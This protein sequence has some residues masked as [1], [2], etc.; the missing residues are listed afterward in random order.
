MPRWWTNSSACPP[1]HPERARP[2][3]YPMNRLYLLAL[4]GLAA[5]PWIVYSP[6]ILLPNTGHQGPVGIFLL[7]ISAPLVADIV[8]L[9]FR[10]RDKST[11]QTGR[12]LGIAIATLWVCHPI[13]LES[14]LVDRIM[15]DMTVATLLAINL[16]LRARESTSWP[17]LLTCG[18]AMFCE[19]FYFSHGRPL[20]PVIVLLIHWMLPGKT[21][22]WP[23]RYWIAIWAPVLVALLLLPW[24]QFYER[25]VI[26][27]PYASF[28][29]SWTELIATQPFAWAE[30]LSQLVWPHPTAFKA[31]MAPTEL[32]P[33]WAVILI[34]AFL[35]LG[36]AHLVYWHQ[37]L[38]G[39]LILC[40]VLAMA[41]TTT[42]PLDIGQF[43]RWEV[44]STSFLTLAWV[45]I[46]SGLVGLAFLTCY[47]LLG[48]KQASAQ[49]IVALSMTLSIYTGLESFRMANQVANPLDM[50]IATHE[51][52]PNTAS[53]HWILSVETRIKK[54]P[55]LERALEHA[56]QAVSLRPR[57]GKL[58]KNLA[59]VYKRLRQ[60]DQVFHEYRLASRL[61]PQVAWIGREF[62]EL[63]IDR[64]RVREA[65][66]LLW[67]IIRSNESYNE[68]EYTTLGFLMLRQTRWKEAEDAFQNAIAAQT[69]S[70]EPE[71]YFGLGSAQMATGKMEAAE[72]NF[73]EAIDLRPEYSD[74][75]YS[76][77]SLLTL[78]ATEQ[79]DREAAMQHLLQA[80]EADPTNVNARVLLGNQ[81]MLAG[82]PVDAAEQFR[83]AVVVS[84]ENTQARYS[85]ATA[86]IESN[87]YAEAIP[88]LEQTIRREPNWAD[89]ALDLGWIRASLDD[90]ALRNGEEALAIIERLT[91]GRYANDPRV[92]D[93]K[94]A[95]LAE[96]GRFDEAEDTAV[97]AINRAIETGHEDLALDV[98][99]RL[100]YYNL[101]QP[102]RI[103]Q[104]WNRD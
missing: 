65:E 1:A 48:G 72:E 49:A 42:I 36:L 15:L 47:R 7:A 39:F 74:A 26:E 90:P 103:R 50:A 67:R 102:Y 37:S 94:A 55:N 34:A 33:A 11:E 83:I 78:T 8:R 92:L 61:A 76:L 25:R 85:L 99:D 24:M 100:R 63:L 96:V 54:P 41:R 5:I 56:H 57:D 59:D 75:H 35:V 20:A 21:V 51:E 46:A 62:S 89:A 79:S 23:R 27:P 93:L 10:L 69:W 52:F 29:V 86:L 64:D 3:I 77:A 95:A 53:S 14:V 70:R 2:T 88:H 43:G 38:L 66:E 19:A 82:Q 4:V 22:V 40:F 104:L 28:D 91:A 68:T 9:F 97:Q 81:L 16:A 58:H 32:I 13:L 87:R 60:V 80:I 31:T 71:M 18:L 6:L 84:P 101:G 44:F 98:Q 12:L 17:L 45:P 30:A 73:R